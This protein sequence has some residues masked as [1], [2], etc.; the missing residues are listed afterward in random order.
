MIKAGIYIHFP[1]CRAK[2]IYC[3]FYSVAQQEQLIPRF[4]EALLNEI[5]HWPPD[6]SDWQFDTIFFGGGTP[7]LLTPQQLERILLALGERFDL[8]AMRELT[9]EANPETV[10]QDKLRAW[11]KLGINRLSLGIQS[12]N[13][14]NL[15]FLGRTHSAAYGRAAIIS[16][17]S[18]GF[19]NISCDLIYGLPG[20]DWEK[21]CCDLQIA[22]EF[23]PAHLSCYALTVEK[24]THLHDLVESESV[25]LPS[26][27][28]GAELFR[29]TGEFLTG[30]G[31]PRYEIS[32][33]ARPGKECRHNQHYWW[34]EP[35]LGF[36]PS[37]HGFDGRRR[38]WNCSDLNQY[39]ERIESDQ[40]VIQA[41][42]VLTVHEHTNERIGFGLRMSEGFTL[43][44]IP[45]QFRLSVLNQL[46]RCLGKWS[47]QLI[48][49][50]ERVRLTEA[51]M[52]FADSIT[53]DLLLF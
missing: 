11:R 24:G 18:A 39:L 26:D 31:Y 52:V 22:L 44:D 10:D 7:S 27:E 40:S 12:F 38:W 37:A 42:E 35:Y 8:S 3:D 1:F 34:I 6:I 46:N 30:N 4:I 20:Q 25:L 45:E 47:G 9:I 43:A 33:F 41:T 28:E 50:G 49:E 13:D 15:R 48:R 14:D 5:K 32:N 16:A 36:G 17:Q 53:V 19:E 29:R 51:G 23:E 2:C 21:W